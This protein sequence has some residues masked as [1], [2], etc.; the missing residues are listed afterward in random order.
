MMIIRTDREN[1]V[2][3]K[4]LFYG[5]IS[6]AAPERISREQRQHDKRAGRDS[7]TDAKRYWSVGHFHAVLAGRNRDRPHED[8]RGVDGHEI[9]V[10]AGLPAGIKVVAADQPSRSS[11]AGIDDDSMRA[12]FDEASLVV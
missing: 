3:G 5:P 11:A 12:I 6:D 8:V 7:A 2:P 1:E 9:P 4:G 10:N